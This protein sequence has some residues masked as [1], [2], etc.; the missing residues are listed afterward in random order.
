[1]EALLCYPRKTVTDLPNFFHE[2]N[3]HLPHIIHHGW[4]LQQDLSQTGPP[5]TIYSNTNLKKISYFVIVAIKEFRKI[6]LTNLQLT[7]Q[8]RIKVA[9]GLS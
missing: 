1:M 3:V 4:M 7:S 9:G 5:S 2:Q 8:W 6:T